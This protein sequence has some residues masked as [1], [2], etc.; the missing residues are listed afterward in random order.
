MNIL[1]NSKD[2]Y[3]ELGLRY[4]LL[5]LCHHNYPIRLLNNA[6]LAGNNILPFLDIIILPLKSCADYRFAYCLSR[7]FKGILI[8]FT[9]DLR[10]NK[11]EILH[12]GNIIWLNIRMDLE[13][14]RN[15]LMT[16][17]REWNQKD[18]LYNIH[19]E[20][21]SH[22]SCPLSSKEILIIRY[23]SRGLNVHDISQMMNIRRKRLY[24]KR[25]KIKRNFHISRI[26]QFHKFMNGQ[27]SFKK[28]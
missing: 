10:F 8:G 21:H 16:I 14:I 17:T 3:L 24:S 7:R 26:H 28:I 5:D 4:C 6:D 9:S 18:H 1:I 12:S 22:Y 2:I 15:V 11:G 23:F 27:L 20:L 19:R 13:C 25:D